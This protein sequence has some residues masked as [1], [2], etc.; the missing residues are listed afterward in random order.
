MTISTLKETLSGLPVSKN[1][2]RDKYF[3]NVRLSE[4]EKIALKNFDRYRMEYL[5]SAPNEEVFEKRY[6]EIQAKAN[7]SAFTDFLNEENLKID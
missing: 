5:N 6:L 3:E 7:L 2:V 4:Q 1:D